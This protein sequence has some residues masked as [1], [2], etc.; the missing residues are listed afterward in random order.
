MA[1]SEAKKE[2]VW[3][4]KFLTKTQE[5]LGV[6]LPLSLYCGKNKAIAQAKE[7]RS[8][9]KSKHIEQSYHIIQENVGRGDIAME[10]IALADNF[11][12][13]LTK[14]LSQMVLDRYLEKMGVRYHTGWY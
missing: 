6:E 12:D 3:I 14:P 2:I 7:A 10:K 4:K 1:D 13:P 11:A 5:V 8:H 9:K